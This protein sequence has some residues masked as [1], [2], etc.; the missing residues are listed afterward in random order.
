MAFVSSDIDTNDQLSICDFDADA[1][2]DADADVEQVANGEVDKATTPSRLCLSLSRTGAVTSVTVFF[3]TYWMAR[4]AVKAVSIGINTAAIPVRIGLSAASSA[5]WGVTAG[6]QTACA[7]QALASASEAAGDTAAHVTGLGLGALAGS[8]A[9]VTSLVASTSADLAA[10]A[11][12]STSELVHVVLRD[13]APNALAL[14][15]RATEAAIDQTR[16]LAFDALE[17]LKTMVKTR[18]RAYAWSLRPD[19]QTG[20]FI[21]AAILHAMH[22]DESNEKD[23][24]DDPKSLS[25]RSSSSVYD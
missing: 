17:S 7:L 25:L 14:A 22:D 16:T 10:R 19:Q 15:S 18:E 13:T 2:A 9:V 24:S 5:C 11:A 4:A 20:G 1:D 6:A 12:T 3:A 21:D 8:V 23:V